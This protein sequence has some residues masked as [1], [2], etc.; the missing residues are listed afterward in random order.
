M[1]SVST[2]I[3]AE[4]VA[5]ARCVI[6]IQVIPLGHR[7]ATVSVKTDGDA[8]IHT[9]EMAETE[10]TE[11]GPPRKCDGEKVARV[12][13]WLTMGTAVLVVACA[14]F[15]FVINVQAMQRLTEW[16]DAD[17]D[18]ASLWVENALGCFAIQL[19][20]FSLGV[21]ILLAE[22]HVPCIA[23][24]LGFLAFRLGRG[25]CLLVIGL[26]NYTY[27]A[28]YVKMMERWPDVNDDSH[29]FLIVSGI[30]AFSVGFLTIVF[31]LL[32]SCCVLALP[33]DDLTEH[34]RE[35][36]RASTHRGR[37][38]PTDGRR[39]A[40]APSSEYPAAATACGS[41]TRGTEMTSSRDLESGGGSGDGS[42]DG[43]AEKRKSRWGWKKKKE[44]SAKPPSSGAPPVVSIVQCDAGGG[45]DVQQSDNPFLGRQASGMAAGAD[46]P[47][48]SSNKV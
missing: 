33:P 7:S 13:R 17:D 3:G 20:L 21:A 42:G 35:I 27:S 15:T 9:R 19:I 11:T 48:M 23:R 16:E 14:V 18:W 12:L 10:S 47:F 26:V 38:D 22:V 32:P 46:N 30:I 1:H 6:L 4:R 31:C 40:N 37:T 24:Y 29:M 36:Q 45:G 25:V 5:L 34:F 2:V 43:K 39:G 28:S 44:S 8:L 41:N